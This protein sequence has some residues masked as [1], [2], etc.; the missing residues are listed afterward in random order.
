MLACNFISPV[1][2]TESRFLQTWRMATC[3]VLRLPSG[4]QSYEAPLPRML[5]AGAE[6][7]LAT[8]PLY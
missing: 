8:V 2:L 3:T 1:L 7:R 4:T 6:M 5:R